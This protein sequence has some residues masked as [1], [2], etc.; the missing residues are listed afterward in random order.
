M[1]CA[2][3]T[4]VSSHAVTPERWSTPRLGGGGG[5]IGETSDEDVDELAGCRGCEVEGLRAPV[6]TPQAEIDEASIEPP[7]GAQAYPLLIDRQVAP[8]RKFVEAFRLHR[9]DVVLTERKW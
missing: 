5:R 1:S 9:L 4:D 3:T 7:G 2:S 8:H 6:V